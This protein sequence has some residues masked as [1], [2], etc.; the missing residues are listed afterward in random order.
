LK[1]VDARDYGVAF[2]AQELA[3]LR[4]IFPQGVCDWSRPGVEFR[5]VEVGR[6]YG[7]ASS[8]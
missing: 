8:T 3:Q 2:D 5:K 6:S 1:P 4:E 7:P